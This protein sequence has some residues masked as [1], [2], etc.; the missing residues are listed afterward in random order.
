[1]WSKL[2]YYRFVSNKFELSGWLLPTITA[3]IPLFPIILGFSL[4]Y[5]PLFATVVLLLV[6]VIPKFP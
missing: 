3:L 5:P 4:S 1:M 2:F 6:L